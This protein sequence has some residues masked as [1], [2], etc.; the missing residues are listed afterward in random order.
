[1]RPELPPNFD[2]FLYN[3]DR[4]EAE[5]KVHRGYTR[6]DRISG[7]PFLLLFAFSA[8]GLVLGFLIQ[9]LGFSLL[10]PVLIAVFLSTTFLGPIVAWLLGKREMRDLLLWALSG[11]AALAATAFVL[12]VV[13]SPGILYLRSLVGLVVAALIAVLCCYRFLQRFLRA[14]CHDFY[15]TRS[16]F[17][18]YHGYSSRLRL[19]RF[20]KGPGSEREHPIERE[21]ATFVAR[22]IVFLLLV[23]LAFGLPLPFAWLSGN[24]VVSMAAVVFSLTLSTVVALFFALYGV[25]DQKTRVLSCVPALLRAAFHPEGGKPSRIAAAV[26]VVFLSL[27]LAPLACYFPL[28]LAI[29]GPQDWFEPPIVETVDNT[30]TPSQEFALRELKT[31]RERQEYLAR[32][33]ER[34]T[35]EAQRNLDA[36]LLVH[37]DEFVERSPSSWLLLFDGHPGRLWL[38]ALS[39]LLVLAAPIWIFLLAVLFT[40]ARIAQLYRHDLIEPGPL[41]FRPV[42]HGSDAE[43]W[44]YITEV[45]HGR[46]NLLSELDWIQFSPHHL[47]YRTAYLRQL[48]H[49]FMGFQALNGLPF[50]LPRNRLCHHAHIMGITG[51]GKTSLSITPLA[52]Q[53]IQR[54]DSCVIY[55]DLKGERSLFADAR[56]AAAKAGAPFKWFSVTKD[57]S[58]YLFNPLS[59][60]RLDA[61]SLRQIAEQVNVGLGLDHGEGYGASY[62]GRINRSWLLR[63]LEEHPNVKSLAELSRIA[64]DTAS[65]RGKREQEGAGETA[66]AL[67]ILERIESLNFTE[68]NTPPNLR[69]ALDN[70]IHLYD[71]MRERQVLYFHLPR[72]QEAASVRDIGRILVDLIFKMA[73]L[74]N[75]VEGGQHQTFVVIDEFQHVASESFCHILEQARGYGLSFLLSHQELSQL[76]MPRIPDLSDKIISNTHF[77][78]C[79]S[80]KG[81]TAEYLVRESGEASEDFE[82]H[83]RGESEAESDAQWGK[84]Y[85][86]SNSDVGH[87]E[88]APRFRPND[89]IAMSNTPKRSICHSVMDEGLAA[90]FGMSF[91]NDSLYHIPQAMYEERRREPWPP[92]SP[93]TITVGTDV[94]AA[95]AA[96]T[97]PSSNED[98]LRKLFEDDEEGG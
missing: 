75:E 77:K 76:K 88:I 22:Q 35:A 45:L 32:L 37:Y 61:F 81:E 57:Y 95:A 28:P 93:E 31:E 84:R 65:F 83:T 60:K 16:T 36:E 42:L 40:S 13:Y 98:A 14:C 12:L 74:V 17:E 68:D 55:I 20:R 7:H 56:A 3:L 66:A 59:Q 53:L 44:S 50:L 18:T 33:A 5:G 91:M 1:M 46:H 82:T 96:P 39:L 85:T 87:V 29:F 41:R 52:N 62:F 90:F 69:K 23:V 58:S 10:Q 25:G 97:A 4:L 79:F 73:Y 70:Q 94:P 67:E 92:A 24:P 34:R 48:P 38:G 9:W 2:I 71:A 11:P 89:I 78:Q 15:V 64:Q 30:P 47:F 51:T 26:A 21:A 49:L 63:T 86:Y 43:R 6:P 80:A 8:L 27:T 19:L 72:A 54:R